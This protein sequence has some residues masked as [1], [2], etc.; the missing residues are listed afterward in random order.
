[1]HAVF[2]E[3]ILHLSLAAEPLYEQLVHTDG[4]SIPATA[5]DPFLRFAKTQRL[6]DS[7]AP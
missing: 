2:S 7:L 6:P 4:M 3:L 1:M 5:E